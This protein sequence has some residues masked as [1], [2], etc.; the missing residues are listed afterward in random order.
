M[1][2]N[3][4]QLHCP[5]GEA[6]AVLSCFRLFEAAPAGFVLLNDQGAILAVNPA[7]EAILGRTASELKGMNVNDPR[8]RALRPDGTDFPPEEFPVM[9][10][11]ASGEPVREALLGCFS[12]GHG[13]FRWLRIHAVPV[14]RPGSDRPA[15][16]YAL[17]DDVTEA[18]RAALRDHWRSRALEAVAR[19]ALLKDIL[20]IIVRGVES[21]DESVV[22]TVLL[23][24]SSGAKLTTGAAPGLPEAYNLGVD[25]LPIAIGSG[26]CGS[27][28]A[29][30]ERVVVDD[31]ETHPYWTGYRELARSAGL[32]SCWS[33]P[34]R[35]SQ[36]R[37]LGTFALYHRQPSVPTADDI[38]C[39]EG[40]AN[41][42]A[43]A[44][45]HGNAL[46]DLERQA[47][48]DYLTG[49]DN[50]RCFIEKAEV[51]LARAERYGGEMSLLML[52]VDR[53]KDVNDSY[54]HK[55]GDRVLQSLSATCRAVLREVD[56]IGRL[57]GEEFGILLPETPGRQALEVAERLREAV[58]AT[59]VNLAD[60]RA[61]NYTVSI[62]VTTLDRQHADLDTL[63]GQADHVLYAAK[64]AGRNRV[65]VHAS[66]WHDGGSNP[67]Q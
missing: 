5:A 59:A 11:L 61:V 31:I 67:P 7:A 23:V 36:G 55:V 21:E 53:F 8:W 22:C 66:V 52:D 34:I 63:F 35:S 54:G 57:G 24:D 29:S 47:R 15:Q 50:R 10:A 26:S 1:A 27:A 38:E 40:A 49:L 44:I 37:V 65:V 12:P 9:R 41:L 51:E 39:I 13:D 46:A 64:D 18:R 17:F 25:G 62:G 20:E 28:A 43:V 16:V 32:R 48:T 56:V 45:E 30:G 42:A 2:Q 3:P 58:A 6:G 60:G 33:E 4:S 14:F 19:G